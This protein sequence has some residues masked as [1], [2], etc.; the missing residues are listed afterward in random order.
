MKKV[1]IFFIPFLTG[2]YGE[3]VAYIFVE[4]RIKRAGWANYRGATFRLRRK[5]LELRMEN[6]DIYDFRFAIYDFFFYLRLSA[7]YANDYC[8]RLR[9]DDNIIS[10]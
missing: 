10:L 5:N 8:P 1:E 4:F 6:L 3:Y 7:V 9:E 2:T